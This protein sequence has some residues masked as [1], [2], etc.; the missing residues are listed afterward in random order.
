MLVE[1]CTYV[2]IN[3][4]IIVTKQSNAS[5]LYGPIYMV[6]GTWD[7]PP[8]RGSFIERLYEKKNFPASQVKV[9]PT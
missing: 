9:D 4:K 3:A 8:Y 6:S 2:N 7:N 1:K 5:V